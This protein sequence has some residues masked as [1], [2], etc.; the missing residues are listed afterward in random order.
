MLEA[1]VEDDAEVYC[2]CWRCTF[3]SIDVVAR[4]I[5]PD[6]YCPH[7]LHGAY[8]SYYYGHDAQNRRNRHILLLLLV[9][10]MVL[11]LYSFREVVQQHKT[12]QAMPR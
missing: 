5:C 1:V 3:Y 6:Y 7:T 9:G 10:A 12:R 4:V 11:L 8:G 2:Y